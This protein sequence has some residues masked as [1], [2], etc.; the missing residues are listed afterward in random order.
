MLNQ[1][2]DFVT[3]VKS[4]SLW[5]KRCENPTWPWRSNGIKG[6]VTK[7]YF[8]CAGTCNILREETFCKRSFFFFFKIIE[9]YL[10]TCNALS[11]WA[12]RNITQT[13]ERDRKYF[14]S[15]I[16]LVFAI[17]LVIYKCTTLERI[18]LR[19]LRNISYVWRV[20][21]I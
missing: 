20:N 21:Y 19:I 8:L 9:K 11:W 10:L 3:I 7:L 18:N 1:F 14:K 12:A 16:M 13:S 15:E 2:H 6:C 5:Q 4:H 17:S